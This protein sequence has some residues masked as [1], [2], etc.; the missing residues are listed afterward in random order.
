MS[1]SSSGFASSTAG[2]LGLEGTAGLAEDEDGLAEGDGLATGLRRIE[3]GIEDGEPSELLSNSKAMVA[4][5]LISSD[6][7][8]DTGAEGAL[9]REDE[10]DDVAR[11]DIG[12]LLLGYGR[13]HLLPG[14]GNRQAQQSFQ[15][16]RLHQDALGS[17]LSI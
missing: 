16:H 3:G 9:R 10:S 14:N 13:G 11:L 8:K 5:S 4:D 2:V 12:Q 17:L 1:S 6:S 7:G 15:K